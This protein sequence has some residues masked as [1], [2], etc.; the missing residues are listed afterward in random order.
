MTNPIFH[1]FFLLLQIRASGEP[2][3]VRYKQ[4]S[5]LHASSWTVSRLTTKKRCTTRIWIAFFF[6]GIIPRRTLLVWLKY[7]RVPTIARPIFDALMIGHVKTI[8]KLMFACFR[9]DY[10]SIWRTFNGM[11]HHAMSILFSSNAGAF[12]VPH[13]QSSL[14]GWQD[15]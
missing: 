13:A 10:R 5:H 8:Q 3:G 4:T 12:Q 11:R 15:M 2:L 1:S 9:S 6:T 7:G 14:P